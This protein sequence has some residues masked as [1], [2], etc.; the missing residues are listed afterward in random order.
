MEQ[1]I[2]AALLHE[3][4]GL[5]IPFDLE[6]NKSALTTEQFR[7]TRNSYENGLRL[8]AGVPD[9]QG[10]ANVITFQ[11]EHFDGD[12]L[13]DGLEGEKIPYLSRILA[14]ANAFDE[15]NTCRNAALWSMSGEPTE[16]LRNKAG[17]ALDP[18]IV[19]VCLRLKL[20]KPAA[21]LDA[22]RPET[23]VPASISV[24]A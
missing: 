3:A 14:V 1:L 17:N 19:E 10:V 12:G 24:G 22:L 2:F 13:F 21:N 9:L 6:M 8:I 4:P 7:V 20:I 16:R 15:I 5:R 18:Q 11:H 23:R